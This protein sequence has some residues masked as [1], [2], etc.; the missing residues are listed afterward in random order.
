M[1]PTQALDEM[2]VAIRG[3][4]SARLKSVAEDYESVRE[5]RTLEAHALQALVEAVEDALDE[6]DCLG[7]EAMVDEKPAECVKC[8][9]IRFH[10]EIY[11][12][13]RGAA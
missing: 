7:G 11:D 9:K 2:L 1:T 12:K 3:S 5:N 6:C 13:A 10:K 8:F 4:A